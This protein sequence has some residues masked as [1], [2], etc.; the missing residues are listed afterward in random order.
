M[1]IE[2]QAII[3]KNNKF[4]ES[5]SIVE[6][7]TREHG[8]LKGFIRSSK[9][10]QAINDGSLVHIDL[11]ARLESHLGT[12]KVEI[13]KNYLAHIGFDRLKIK[14]LKCILD[15]STKLLR[16]RDP[17]ARL[18]DNMI[19]FLDKLCNEPAIIE[20]L[21]SY[22]LLE[23]KFMEEAGYGLD[24]SKCVVTNT[25]ED[26]FYISPKSGCAV[27]REAGKPYDDKLF[28]MPQF[29]LKDEVSYAQE[30]DYKSVIEALNLNEFFLW[31]HVFEPNNLKMPEGRDELVNLVVAFR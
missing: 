17:H 19:S 13:I 26:L 16:E 11:R 22:A 24:L 10:S 14:L 3:L 27:S 21:K 12:L 1:H 23:V 4:Q 28:K 20:I 29:Y 15:M 2:G 18:Y 25:T 5:S 31:K 6:C 30:S 8:V 9:V 7:F